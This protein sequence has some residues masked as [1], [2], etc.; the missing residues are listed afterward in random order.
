MK[1]LWLDNERFVELSESTGKQDIKQVQ[2]LA[3]EIETRERVGELWAQFFNT[4]ENPDPVLR[5]TG[6]IITIFDEVKRDPQ[7][8]SCM[9]GRRSGV[10]KLNWRIEQNDASTKAVDAIET[11]FKTFKMHS[12]IREIMDA[13]F[14]G[15]QVQELV[16]GVVDGYTI[17]VK[18]E[19]KPAEWFG[20]DYNNQLMRKNNAFD[21]YVPAEY[22]KFLLS[23]NNATYKNP[24]GEGLLSMCF[25]PV[26]FKKGG[27]KFWAVFLEKFG[28]PQQ[29]S[30]IWTTCPDC[31]RH[32][33]AR[34]PR[35]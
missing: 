34:V 11:I 28:M 7:V 32:L 25:W 19:Q 31:A 30:I 6:N 22:H 9:T 3:E 13:L 4:I 24:Y 27:V 26:T 10:Q 12:V 16:W 21:D 20:F 17:P 23:R 8:S 35:S 2:F 1:R 14:Y 29:R 5:K 18:I 15:Y 33:F